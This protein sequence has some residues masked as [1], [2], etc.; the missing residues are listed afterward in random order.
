MSQEY[1]SHSYQHS[2]GNH[3]SKHHVRQFYYKKLTKGM[4][5]D[6]SANLVVIT[7]TRKV[8]IYGNIMCHTMKLEK[9]VTKCVSACT[10]AHRKAKV[11]QIYK[12]ALLVK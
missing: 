6:S 4:P 12:T 8:F 9:N 3:H 5:S 2:R 1:A 7:L 10:H 11:G